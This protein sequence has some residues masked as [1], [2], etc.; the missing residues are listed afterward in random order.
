MMYFSGVIVETFVILLEHNEKGLF[1]IMYT[2]FKSPNPA[3]SFHKFD[4]DE[5]FLFD[6][7]V[8]YATY[9]DLFIW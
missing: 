3:V 5:T 9:F 2:I 1:L 6:L 7:I 8:S 4:C